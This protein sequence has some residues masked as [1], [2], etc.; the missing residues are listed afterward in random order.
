MRFERAEQ[1]DACVLVLRLAEARESIEGET[2]RL[3]EC[4][5]AV[6]A[7]GVQT[8]DR[9][10]R[11]HDGARVLEDRLVGLV[12]PQRRADGLFAGERVCVQRPGGR[13]RRRL[14]GNEHGSS[15]DDEHES[16]HG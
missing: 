16:E 11:R 7:R 5:V 2:A 8:H 12:A 4:V 10:V 1:A 15:D 3:P 14:A 13:G 9:F 6:A